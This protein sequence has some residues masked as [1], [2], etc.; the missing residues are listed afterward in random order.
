MV[1]LLALRR[2]RLYRVSL[3]PTEGIFPRQ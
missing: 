1:Y 3:A 2:A